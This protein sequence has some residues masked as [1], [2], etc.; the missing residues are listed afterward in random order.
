MIHQI[1]SVAFAVGV[2]GNL[3]ASAIL[4]VPALIHIHKKLDRHQRREIDEIRLGYHASNDNVSPP[5][6]ANGPS[7]AGSNQVDK[8]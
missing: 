7:F 6:S 2:I 1:L 4:G 3:V 8:D 5:N